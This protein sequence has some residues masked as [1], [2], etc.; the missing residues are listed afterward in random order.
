MSEVANKI[1]PMCIQCIWVKIAEPTKKP[2]IAARMTRS[3]FPI[4]HF[5][6]ISL[7]IASVSIYCNLFE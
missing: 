4:L 7:K 1:H 6:L 3:E 5:M 2:P